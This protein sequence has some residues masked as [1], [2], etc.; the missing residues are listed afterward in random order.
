MR[1]I[2]RAMRACENGSR[3]GDLEGSIDAS[4]FSGVLLGKSSGLT[5]AANTM[6]QNYRMEIATIEPPKGII[7]N[8]CYSI[9]YVLSAPDDD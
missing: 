3:E 5:S 6:I 1:L 7:E 9:G 2:S 8:L 4:I